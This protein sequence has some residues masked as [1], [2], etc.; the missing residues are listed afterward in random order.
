MENEAASNALGQAREYLIRQFPKLFIAKNLSPLDFRPFLHIWK[1]VCLPAPSQGLPFLPCFHVIATAAFNDADKDF[2]ICFSLYSF[3]GKLLVSD[4]IRLSKMDEVIFQELRDMSNDTLHICQGVKGPELFKNQPETFTEPLA[5][6][7]VVRTKECQYAVNVLPDERWSGEMIQCVACKE[8]K[9]NEK[10]FTAL[11][12]EIIEQEMDP[13]YFAEGQYYDDEEEWKEEDGGWNEDIQNESDDSRN[14][15]SE[16][17]N[18]DEDSKIGI[19]SAKPKKKRGPRKPKGERV[20]GEKKEKREKGGGDGDKK[21]RKK[22]IKCKVCLM[23]YHN[24]EQI[25]ECIAFHKEVMNL[26]AAFTCPLCNEELENKLMVTDHF[27][28]KHPGE[29]TCCCECGK[30]INFKQL[31]AHIILEHHGF[32]APKSGAPPRGRPPLPLP[33]QEPPKAPD[34]ANGEGGGTN[35]NPVVKD[36]KPDHALLN[37]APFKDLKK[38]LGP[39]ERAELLLQKRAVRAMKK[40]EAKRRQRAHDKELGIVRYKQ[41]NKK[42]HEM[43]R[44]P[45]PICLHT[46]TSK[47]L[48]LKCISRHEDALNLDE[49]VSCPMCIIPLESKRVLTQHFALHHADTGKTACC[50]CLQIMPVENDRLRRHMIKNHHTAGKPEICPQCGKSLS[51]ARELKLHLE[52]HDTNGAI[53]PECGKFFQSRKQMV[54]HVSQIHRNKDL[55][56]PYC[57]KMFAN[58]KQARKHVA[59]HTGIKPY[60]CPECNYSAHTSTNVN[61]HVSKSHGKRGGEQPNIIVDEEECE[62]MNQ[63]LKADLARMFAMKEESNK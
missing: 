23:C 27:N 1:P 16:M 46:Y 51:S 33:G 54:L 20:P 59:M 31:G 41:V 44:R 47:G 18:A 9:P 34:A 56:C 13:E 61:D 57:E 24:Q 10:A 17:N 45:C 5:D 60:R 39:R 25:D 4:V 15:D 43:V 48:I 22:A 28:M 2:N 63:I 6:N 11:K 62:R 12:T 32:E 58:R 30:L 19:L 35:G 36:E 3:H 42:A 29:I 49:P 14:S 50:E 38:V 55:K 40:V 26:D 21:A 53:C 37:S 8:F 52:D 7:V